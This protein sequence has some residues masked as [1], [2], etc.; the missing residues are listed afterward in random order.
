[1]YSSLAPGTQTLSAF[2]LVFALA[3]GDHASRA[4]AMAAVDTTSIYLPFLAHDNL[5]DARFLETK[6]ELLRVALDDPDL[7]LPDF[8]AQTLFETLLF[9]GRFDEAL[10]VSHHPAVA[11]KRGE[12]LYEAHLRGFAVPAHELAAELALASADTADVF[13]ML[14]AGAFAAERGRWGDHARALAR[15][16][17][18]ARDALR[19]ADSTRA[20]L[21]RGAALALQGIESWRRDGR[22][23]EARSAL[24]Q[25]RASVTGHFSEEIANRTI[26]WWLAEVLIQ[27]GEPREAKRYFRALASGDAFVTDPVAAYRLGQLE[28]RLGENREAREDYNYFLAAWRAPDHALR[29][30]VDEARQ[31]ITR[32]PGP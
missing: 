1:M 10:A 26:R 27:S 30:W 8:A 28:E 29:P 17:S 13:A 31:A 12:L 6:C 3:F 2:R 7:F 32:L 14:Y 20:R 22:L 4:S 23:V 19:G 5:S 15:Q 16:R 25:A 24:D 21:A 11:K 18:I 9:R